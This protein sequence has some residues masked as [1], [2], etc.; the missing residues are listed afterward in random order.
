MPPKST[1]LR[2]LTVIA[3]STMAILYLGVIGLLL[4]LENRLVY[5]PRPAAKGWVPPPIDDIQEVF[6]DSADGN[7]LCAWW[8]PCPGSERSLLYLHGNA[9]NLS[10]RGDS[11]IKLRKHLDTSVLIVDYPGYGKSAGEPS[12]A[13]CYLAADAGYDYLVNPQMRD[14]KKLIVFGASLGGG[15]AVDLATRKPHHALVVVKSFTSLPDVGGKMF[16]WIPV[17]WIMRNQFRS[18]D[19]I[20]TLHTPVFIAHGDRDTI[21]PFEQSEVLFKAATEPKAFLNLKGQDHNDSFPLEFF[22]ELQAFL[23]KNEP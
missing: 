3:L 16:P 14:P 15:V 19:K 4:Y 5:H 18:I 11:I 17:R 9:G 7:R 8:L 22:E 10:D 23:K 6:L 13:G 2:R 1:S 21:I 20:G 12:E